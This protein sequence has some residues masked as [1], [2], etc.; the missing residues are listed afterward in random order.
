MPF[1]PNRA[2][3]ISTDFM[4]EEL[5]DAYAK[6]LEGISTGG[7]DDAGKDVVIDEPGIPYIQVKSSIPKAIAFLAEGVRRK[8][9]THIVVGEPGGKDEMLDTI[10]KYGGWVGHNVPD[11]ER[12]L[13]SIS[14]AREMCEN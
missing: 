11:R 14:K 1:N 8:R 2:P 10:R 6:I 13:E 3:G 4:G 5:E 12:Y 7:Y 9:F